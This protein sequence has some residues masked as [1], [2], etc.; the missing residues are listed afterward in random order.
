MSRDFYLL[1]REEVADMTI[2]CAVL[3]E[4]RESQTTKLTQ[5]D[6][7]KGAG[8]SRTNYAKKEKGDV[9]LTLSDLEKLSDFY[10]VP[11]WQILHKENSGGEN[12]KGEMMQKIIEL[13]DV[14]TTLNKLIAKKDMEIEKLKDEL[15]NTPNQP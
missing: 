5:A 10:G 14:I 15:K 1:R 4:L 11:V 13:T 2:N 7:A 8:F 3:K 6:V 9:P 12:A